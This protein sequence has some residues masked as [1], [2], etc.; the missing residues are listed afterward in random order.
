VV[1]LYERLGFQKDPAGVK[2]MA[3]Q[4]KSEEGKFLVA[5]SA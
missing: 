4:R 5:A 3:F 1:S 2:G